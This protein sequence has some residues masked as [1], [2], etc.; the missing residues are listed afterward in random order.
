MMPKVRCQALVKTN[1]KVTQRNKF[2]HENFLKKIRNLKHHVNLF[3]EI[4]QN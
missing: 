2:I 3:E 1:W 4:N